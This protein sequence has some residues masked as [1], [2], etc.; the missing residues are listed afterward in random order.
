MVV[1]TV[2]DSRSEVLPPSSG[3]DDPELRAP[4][5]RTWTR[6]RCRDG[7][8]LLCRE[9]AGPGE[10]VITVGPQEQFVP[11]GDGSYASAAPDRPELAVTR[12]RSAHT[13]LTA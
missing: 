10:Y 11:G 3:E 4:R 2:G 6:P 1:G 12:S 9:G 7:A 8:V 13:A 5:R